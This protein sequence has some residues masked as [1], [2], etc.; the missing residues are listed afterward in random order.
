MHAHRK[1]SMC[2]PGCNSPDSNVRNIYSCFTHFFKN[3]AVPLKAQNGT[4]FFFGGGETERTQA[5]VIY[6]RFSKSLYI[7]KCVCGSSNDKLSAEH[8]SCFK[9]VHI[10]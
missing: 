5:N 8:F 3:V 4:Q 7:F 2:V 1:K 6:F 10:F 9:R